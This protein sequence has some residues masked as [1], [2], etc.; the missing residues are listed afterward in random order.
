MSRRALP[1]A[2]NVEWKC[3][4]VAL[5]CLGAVA[6]AGVAGIVGDLAT[7]AMAQTYVVF[8][9]RV[10]LNCLLTTHMLFACIYERDTYTSSENA[11]QYIAKN[12]LDCADHSLPQPTYLQVCIA[13]LAAL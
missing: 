10:Q 6:V 12:S 4:E 9:L 11:L 8:S 1:V 2:R 3:P 7:L 5:E 13:L